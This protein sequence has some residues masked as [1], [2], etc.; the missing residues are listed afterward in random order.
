MP[1]VVFNHQ[2]VIIDVNDAFADVLGRLR[3]DLLGIPGRDLGFV[4]VESKL[5]DALLW[6]FAGVTE[7][8]SVCCQLTSGEGL[9]VWTEMHMSVSI[10]R[11]HS[12]VLAIVQDRTDEMWDSGS[13]RDFGS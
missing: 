1:M 11:D 6:L 5:D 4:N 13:S 2:G 12:E 7:S 3:G 8:L 9:P 10:G